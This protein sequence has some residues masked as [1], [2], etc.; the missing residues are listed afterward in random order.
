MLRFQ[1][2]ALPLVGLNVTLTASFTVRPLRSCAFWAAVSRGRALTVATSDC[3]T[4]RRPVARPDPLIVTRPAAIPPGLTEP[5]V[6]L[7]LV[8]TTCGLQSGAV[9]RSDFRVTR[10]FWP[11]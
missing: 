9:N 7:P 6:L 1:L 3:R 4:I 10:P 8:D 11:V 2:T 5:L